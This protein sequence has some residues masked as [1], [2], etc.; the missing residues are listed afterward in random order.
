[1]NDAL[2]QELSAVAKQMVTKGKG[3]LAAD[4]STGTCT[5]RF[6]ALGVES[7]EETRQNYRQTIVT[8]EGLENSVAGII[9]FDE[10]FWQK[11][12]DGESFVSVLNKKGILPG[13]KVDTGSK[14]H[15]LF[16][17]E[18]ITSGLDGL[19]ERLAKY[20]EAGAKFA[21]WREVLVID[22]EKDLPSVGNIEAHAFGL[23]RYAGLCQEA[24]IVPIVEP[25][26]LMDGN[27]T[28]EDSEAIT[29]EVLGTLFEILEAQNVYLPGMV[30]KPNM[31]IAG[32]EAENKSTSAE[33]AEATIRTLRNTVPAEVPGIAFLSGGISPEM[34][35]ENLKLMNQMEDLPWNV[36]FS[37]GRAIQQPALEAWSKGNVAEAQK[38]L[39]EFANKNGAATKGE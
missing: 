10:T 4:E 32:T 27:H 5:K 34:A 31:V 1:M 2:K 15:A 30:L 14:P 17:G 37:F 12:D 23:A 38:L 16:E 20:K 18:Q 9:L 8:S 39:V 6:V 26:I 25:E 29:T 36:T 7:T 11:T 35:A 33:V 24:G 21:K 19:R 13:I 22:T 28:I 3:I